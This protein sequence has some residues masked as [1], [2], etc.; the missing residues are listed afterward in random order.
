MSYE[1]LDGI[2]CPQDVVIDQ[3]IMHSK[4]K[5][6]ELVDK[7]GFLF[8]D[9]ID[10]MSPVAVCVIRDHA[11]NYFRLNARE[12]FQEVETCIY[13][14]NANDEFET[15]IGRRILEFVAATKFHVEDLV[16]IWPFME[17]KGFE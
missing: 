13:A 5:V 11:G 17:G 3:A 8:F 10:D 12:C 16:Q 7:Y 6:A 15:Y 2:S 4:L 14:T 9:G 1:N